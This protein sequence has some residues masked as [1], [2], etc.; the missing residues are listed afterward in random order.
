VK[1]GI[2]AFAALAV[3][4]VVAA[5]AAM[6]ATGAFAA[7]S[8]S[9]VTGSASNIG[10]STAVLHGTVNPNGNGTTYYF[11]WG[12]TS[13]YGAAGKALSA[14]SGTK[15]VA[16]K[17]TAGNL[18]P[19]TVYHYRMVAANRYGS[20]VGADHT[21]TTA[22]HPPPDVATGP[23]TG[24]SQN[25]A[26]VTGVINPHGQATSWMFQFGPG[27]AYGYYT[28]GGSVAAGSPPTTVAYP[29][30]A[31]NSGTVYHYRLVATH[32]TGNTT[33][34][35]AD[36]TFMTYPRH[37][38]VPAVRASTRPSR[39]HSRPYAVLTLGVISHPAWIPAQFAC[40]GNVEVQFVHG[41]HQVATTFV[42]VQ[43]SC[44]FGSSL[45]F[46]H[47]HAPLSVRVRFLGNGYL[48][49]NHARRS[50]VRFT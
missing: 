14:G 36:A 18:I 28:G 4:L 22:G 5:L 25:G 7:T 46:A 50:T 39:L 12:L 34:V 32:G 27:T 38:P 40:S 45:V 17:Q 2:E 6:L 23:A 20:S 49:P 41:R 44:A 3:W 9:V 1:R 48:A 21:F 19:G 42:P 35:G 8:P 47:R 16:V 31:L 33:V 10:E 26:T 24:I 29:M 15:P 13:S 37:R 43:P 30:P 11:Q